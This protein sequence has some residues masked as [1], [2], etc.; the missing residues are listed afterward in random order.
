MKDMRL[1]SIIPFQRTLVVIALI[2]FIL[3][4]T[5]GNSHAIGR[6]ELQ[7]KIYN[8]VENIL[9]TNNSNNTEYQKIKDRAKQISMIV[10]YYPQQVVPDDIADWV[11][12]SILELIE[13]RVDYLVSDDAAAKFITHIDNSAERNFKLLSPALLPILRT[14]SESLLASAE[15][16]RME[17]NSFVIIKLSN[18]KTIKINFNSPSIVGRDAFT[19]IVIAMKPELAELRYGSEERGFSFSNSNIG[20]MLLSCA[21]AQK[22]R[23]YITLEEKGDTLSYTNLLSSVLFIDDFK[24]RDFATVLPKVEKLWS[25]AV[26]QDGNVAVI[27][28]D[29]LTYF[30]MKSSTLHWEDDTELNKSENVAEK[31]TKIP[32]YVVFQNESYPWQILQDTVLKNQGN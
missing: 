13:E 8:N 26:T 11:E 22:I 14:R 32:S 6:D 29:A 25:E 9:I 30:L 24:T 18:A 3:G 17:R 12:H 16:Y 2:F 19:N 5:S 20:A 7:I 27:D 28:Y 31:K 21:L 23:S 4:A 10:R 15:E 1:L